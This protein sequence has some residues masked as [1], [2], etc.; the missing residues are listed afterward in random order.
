MV[1][2]SSS[3]ARKLP[4]TMGHSPLWF[5]I[6]NYG[7]ATWVSLAQILWQN[8]SKCVCAPISIL[9]LSNNE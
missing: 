3:Y 9:T 1:C 5:R 7:I 4:S 6:H 2:V 8:T